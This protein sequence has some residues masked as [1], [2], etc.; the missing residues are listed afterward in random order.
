MTP[1]IRPQLDDRAARDRI[2]T[3]LGE[4]LLVEASA[5]TVLAGVPTT[6]VKRE[7]PAPAIRPPLDDRAARERIGTS[8]GESP[9]AGTVLAGVPTTRMKREQPV[10][11]SP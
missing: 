5:G 1:A 6:R 2:R 9:V 3:S 7:Q 4:S 10:R 8:L 11:H